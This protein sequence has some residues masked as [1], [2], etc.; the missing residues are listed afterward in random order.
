VPNF[1]V[2][3]QTVAEICWFIVLT[4]WR[5]A[6]VVYAVIVYLSV[7]LSVRPSHAGIVPKGLNVASRK[8]C[9]T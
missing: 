8:Q 1:V 2:I 4:E 6:S 9:S 5:Y 7:R 3:G